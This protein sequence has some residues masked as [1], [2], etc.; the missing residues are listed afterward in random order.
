M[1]NCNQVVK[2]KEKDVITAED[3]RQDD[4]SLH[5]ERRQTLEECQR[6]LNQEIKKYHAKHFKLSRPPIDDAD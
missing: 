1:G 6:L 5:D 2:K 3:F 4:I